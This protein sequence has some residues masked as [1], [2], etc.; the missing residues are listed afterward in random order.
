M[1]PVQ[2]RPMLPRSAH[3]PTRRVA[4]Q[5]GL[6]AVAI[7]LSWGSWPVKAQT[8]SAPYPTRPIRLLVGYP[9]GGT[10]D[11]LARTLSEGLSVQLG[12]AVLVDNRAGANGNL[13]ADLVAKST[14]DGYTWMLSAP[15]PLAVHESLYPSLPFEPKTAFAPIARVAVAPLVLLVRSSLPVHDLRSL[16]TYMQAHPDKA[17]FASQ[18]NGSSSHLAMA[19]LKVRTGMP[20]IHVPYKGAAPALNDLMAGHITV[21]FDNTAS[22]LPHVRSGS[23]RAIAVAQDQRIAALPD[24]PTVAEQGV[25]GYSATPWFGLATTAG[26]PAAVLQTVSAAVHTVMHAPAVLARFEAMGVLPVHDSPAEFA[27]YIES[28]RSKWKEVVRLSGA[29]ID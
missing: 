1:N 17:N 8:L 22:C 21:M 16:Q 9:A 7:G 10:A 28:E 15:G 6:Q 26:T 20:G 2:N 13:A 18:G 11:A 12:Q 29:R 25:P 19:L 4:L 14:P 3:A 5:Q 27:R 24:V 23:L